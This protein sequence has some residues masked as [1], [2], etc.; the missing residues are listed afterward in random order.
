VLVISE[1]A[2]LI[3]GPAAAAIATAGASGSLRMDVVAGALPPLTVILP[4]RPADS[5]T[6]SIFCV[7]KGDDGRL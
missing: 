1:A 6:G 5:T 3:S 2:S 4:F 7:R